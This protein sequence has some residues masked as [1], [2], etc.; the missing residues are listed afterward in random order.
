[1]LPSKDSSDEMKVAYYILVVPDWLKEASAYSF[2]GLIILMPLY[3]SSKTYN[4]AILEIQKEE[5]T[6]TGAK[7]DRVLPIN[8]VKRITLNDVKH[9]I[10]RPKEELEVVINQKDGKTTSFLLRH[11]IQ[12]E[13][14][15][16]ALSAF[17][18][19][20]FLVHSSMFDNVTHDNEES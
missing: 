15:V 1:M 3:G 11:Y 2:V 7:M 19:I 16:E 10:R 17:E 20:D 5:L 18:G 6:I 14:F 4:P 13:Q 12:S 9:L 8:S